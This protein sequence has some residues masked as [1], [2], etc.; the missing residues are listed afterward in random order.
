M[1][2]SSLIIVGT[3]VMFVVMIMFLVKSFALMEDSRD[4]QESSVHQ[5][6]HA[7]QVAQG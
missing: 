5:Q 7:E 4:P 1:D 2:E 3:I 6:R